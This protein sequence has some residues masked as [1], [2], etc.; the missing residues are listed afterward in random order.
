MRRQVEQR[1]PG[2]GGRGAW[3]KSAIAGNI[4]APVLCSSVGRYG[5]PVAERSISPPWW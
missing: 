1:E 3:K 5:E 2:G 4:I